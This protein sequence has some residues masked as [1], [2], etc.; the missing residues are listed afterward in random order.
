MALAKCVVVT[1]ALLAVL[2][3]AFLVSPRLLA[4]SATSG[5]IGANFT[6]T[7]N[8]TAAICPDNMEC[9]MNNTCY[10]GDGQ[11]PRLLPYRDIFTPEMLS[12][13][14]RWRWRAELEWPDALKRH[15]SI[16]PPLPGMQ[17]SYVAA[18]AALVIL[19]WILLTPL[20]GFG[21]ASC[22]AFHLGWIPVN[23]LHPGFRYAR[24]HFYGRNRRLRRRLQ[25]A[26]V[27]HARATLLHEAPNANPTQ[28]STIFVKAGGSPS[29]RHH[30]SCEANNRACFVYFDN[31][32]EAACLVD[33]TVGAELR[34]ACETRRQ[35]TSF[36]GTVF[37]ARTQGVVTVTLIGE[38]NEKIAV[39]LNALVVPHLG[40]AMVLGRPVM[41]KLCN[42]FN[43]RWIEDFATGKIECGPL[44]LNP[45]STELVYDNSTATRVYMVTVRPQTPVYRVANLCLLYARMA[46]HP[47]CWHRPLKRPRL[48]KAKAS[49]I[50]PGIP[51]RY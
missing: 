48:T 16:D 2:A 9:L 35:L 49:P 10:S 39:S 31:G 27:Q 28:A 5:D 3:A 32:S 38:N 21:W 8:L 6:G 20:V 41:T 43:S 30:Y 19:L 36:D 44:I 24:A 25:R 37:T 45:S 17:P 12:A 11:R 13:L 40:A 42:H 18:P 47:R 50:V 1:F 33:G 7:C 34:D 4:R 51:E 15:E 14:E 29:Q 46:V 23:A 26:M 22:A